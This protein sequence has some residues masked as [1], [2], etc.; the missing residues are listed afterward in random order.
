MTASNA[1]H[2]PS[3]TRWSRASIGSS[4][5]RSDDLVDDLA[6][7]LLHVGFLDRLEH[8]FPEGLRIDLFD[9]FDAGF[10]EL[11]ER[12]L[13]GLAIELPLQLLRFLGGLKQRLPMLLPQAIEFLLVHDRDGHGVRMPRHRQVLL[14]LVE[15]VRVNDREWIFLSI[16]RTGL[17]SEVDLSERHRCWDR[18]QDLERLDVGGIRRRADLQ[19]FEI[20]RRA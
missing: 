4:L 12:R 17:Q 15:T 8:S 7:V 11:L 9:H 19:A 13:V 5:S 10:T 14:H 2:T 16:D 20:L 6:A 1:A 3:T 18:S